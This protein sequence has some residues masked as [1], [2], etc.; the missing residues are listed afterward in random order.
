MCNTF[1]RFSPAIDVHFAYKGI[2]VDDM[3]ERVARQVGYPKT[4]RLD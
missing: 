4:I 2:N 1:T 3:L